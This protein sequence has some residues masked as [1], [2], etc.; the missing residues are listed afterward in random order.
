VFSLPLFL[1]FAKFRQM[2]PGMFQTF[3]LFEEF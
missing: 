2:S 3:L 1:L